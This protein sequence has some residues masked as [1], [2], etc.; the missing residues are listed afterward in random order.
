MNTVQKTIILAPFNLLYR[1]SPKLELKLLFWI[2]QGYR[3]N[4][5]NPSTFNEKLQWIK[6]YDRNSL[7]PKCVDKY[8]VRDFVSSRGCGDILNHLLWEGFDTGLIPWTS[9]PDKFVIKITHGSTFNIICTDKSKLDVDF[10]CQKLNKWLK[11]KFLPCYGEWFYGVERPRIIIEK[12][13]EADDLKDY[14]VFC[15]EGKPKYIAVY[16]NR[17]GGK[18]HQEMYDLDWNLISEHTN[19][20]TLPQILTEKPKNLDE[21]IECA[22]KLSRGFHH[23]RVDFFNPDNHLIFGEMTFTSS[24]GFGKFS[25]RRFEEEM[26]SYLKLPIKGE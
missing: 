9:L 20:Y 1:I 25:S 15:F 18:L 16:S 2:K 17:Q 10:V 21:I 24:A 11:M 13:I 5:E 3:L 23:V 22:T 7:M 12:Y 6:L 14:K 4:L 19:H 26:G 8:T